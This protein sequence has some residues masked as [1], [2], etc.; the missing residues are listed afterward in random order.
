ML[1]AFI[2]DNNSYTGLPP[3]LN[4]NSLKHYVEAEYD[5]MK[6]EIRSLIWIKVKQIHGNKFGQLIHDGCTLDNGDKFQWI[7][8]Q[9]VD[10]KF[11]TNHVCSCCHICTSGKGDCVAQFIRKITMEVAGQDQELVMPPLCW[12]DSHLWLLS[13]EFKIRYYN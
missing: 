3:L 2:K 1:L 12:I 11:R 8:L 5:R 10:P 13:R 4:K 9:F 7:G 6:R